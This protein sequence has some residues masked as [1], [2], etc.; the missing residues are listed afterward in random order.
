[1]IMAKG[2]PAGRH[3]FLET[4]YGIKCVRPHLM[5]EIG[6]SGLMSGDGKRGDAQASVLA[7]I[8]DSTS[9]CGAT[10]WN[11]KERVLGSNLILDDDG[12]GG[13]LASVSNV[14]Q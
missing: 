7:P 9:L 6:T 2:L 11:F 4:T 8:L 10:G 5:P 3:I 12:P 13:E 1:M 14:F